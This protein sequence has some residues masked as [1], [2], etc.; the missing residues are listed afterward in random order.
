MTSVRILTNRSVLRIRGP[1]IKEAR[2]A[3]VQITISGDNSL[4]LYG[5]IPSTSI[6][7]SNT[8]YK[9]FYLIRN[10]KQ[11]NNLPQVGTLSVGEE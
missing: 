3:G 5:Q 4:L 1:R 2:N 9:Y 8:L 10:V 6:I 11:S 7:D